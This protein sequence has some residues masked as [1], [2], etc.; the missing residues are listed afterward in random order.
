MYAIRFALAIP[1]MALALI[2][3]VLVFANV[4]AL[5]FLLPQEFDDTG[6]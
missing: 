3:S 5:H 1:L 2:L 4:K 6:P